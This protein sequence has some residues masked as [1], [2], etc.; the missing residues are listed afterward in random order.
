MKWP[1]A[2]RE[3]HQAFCVTERWTEV[4]RATGRR[5]GHHVTYELTLADDRILRTRISH[6][7]NRQ[8]IYGPS[9]WQHILRDQLDVA[10]PEFWECVTNG[11]PPTRVAPPPPRQGIP[12]DL[13]R[14]LTGKAG[15]PETQVRTMTRD[16]AITAAQ[17]YWS[18]GTA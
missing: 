14:L 3:D 9:L 7:P 5:G 4:R 12:V 6:P 11:K 10:E 15:L 16:E 18:R 2:T 8:H 17:T 13:Y 1:A